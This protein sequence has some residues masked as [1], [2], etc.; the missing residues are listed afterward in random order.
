MKRKTT[1]SRSYNA[2]SRQAKAEETR[3]RILATAKAQ[4]SERGVDVV[5][6]DDIASK[7]GVASPTVYALFR[8]KAGLLKAIIQGTFFGPHYARVAERTQTTD[9]PFELLR[10]TAS[11][12]RVIFDAERVEIGLMRGVSAFSPELK[13]VE[14][15]FERIRFHLQ[16]GR[17]RL[18]VKTFPAARKLGLTKVCDIMWMYTGRDIYRMLVLE[19]GWSSDDYEEWLGLTLIQ[20]FTGRQQS[21]ASQRTAQP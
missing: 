2:V 20:A 12:S 18:L 21:T 8:S 3:A 5:T 14:T 15:E 17:A 10:I 13:S 7:A 16:E 11:I 19:R 1:K 6:I 9:D 4:F